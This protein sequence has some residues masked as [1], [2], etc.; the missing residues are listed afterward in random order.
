MTLFAGRNDGI[1]SQAK[2]YRNVRCAFCRS[3]LFVVR[4]HEMKMKV[5]VSFVVLVVLGTSVH[6]AITTFAATWDQSGSGNF[7]AIVGGNK[8]PA[9]TTGAGTAAGLWGTS[10]VNLPNGSMALGY[11]A[12]QSGNI[13]ITSGSTDEYTIESWVK[14]SWAASDKPS[15]D[16]FIF[17]A[18][19][20]NGAW[21]HNCTQIYFTSGTSN[22]LFAVS[23]GGRVNLTVDVSGIWTANTWHH[24]AFTHSEKYN[25]QNWAG[26]IS[27]FI[28]GTRYSTGIPG[29]NGVTSG[30]AD[31]GGPFDQTSMDTT[32]YIG[33]I[34]GSSS[35][36]GVMEDFQI[37][38]YLKY[39]GDYTVPTG[40][41]T[42]EPATMIL[43]G[44]GGLMLRRRSA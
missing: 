34:G 35:I 40:P 31:S 30:W 37:S 14:T 23:G 7:N 10:G 18:Q 28:D 6:G 20:K 39:T 15:G 9:S 24:V 4:R 3:L 8:V 42:P 43:L 38:D 2:W 32:M 27:V 36:N 5:L 16:R 26:V 21:D 44:L 11:D 19:D 22:L 29:S 41:P 25:W 12:A 33:N 1:W 13:P 17:A